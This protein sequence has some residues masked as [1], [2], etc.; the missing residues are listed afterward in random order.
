VI[1]VT[2]LL[3]RLLPLQEALRG[4]HENAQRLRVARMFR[5]ANLI[6]ETLM[7]AFLTLSSEMTDN[8]RMPHASSAVDG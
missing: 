3:F 6:D 1:E 5:E 4:P 7:Q 8:H 2:S